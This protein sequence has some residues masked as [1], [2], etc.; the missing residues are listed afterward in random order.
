MHG[1]MK[2]DDS[3][4]VGKKYNIYQDNLPFSDGVARKSGHFYVFSNLQKS[5]NSIINKSMS[6]IEIAEVEVMSS[7]FRNYSH[8]EGETWEACE[9]RIV[10]KVKV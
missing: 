5:I 2:I 7:G 10:R 6:E 4:V 8:E 9:V 3:Y 1:Y